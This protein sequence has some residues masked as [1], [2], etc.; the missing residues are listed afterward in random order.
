MATIQKM[1]TIAA[2]NFGTPNFKPIIEN[3]P[4]KQ[5][6]QVKDFDPAEHLTFTPPEQVIMMTDL[7]YPA[8]MGVSPVAVSQ[9]FKL[10][11]TEAVHQMRSEI[12]HPQ[13]MKNCGY[14]SNIAASQV[15]GYAPK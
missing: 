7:G 8:D 5:E 12:L 9:P 3:A 2:M 10:F 15:R 14:Q 1:A 6:T 4:S 11:S 13:V